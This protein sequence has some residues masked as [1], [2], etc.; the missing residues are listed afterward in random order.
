MYKKNDITSIFV[1]F[2]RLNYT[3]A[4]EA[5]AAQCGRYLPEVP[6]VAAQLINHYIVFA[7]IHLIYYQS[8]LILYHINVQI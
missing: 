4:A 1:G 2:T 7:I 3:V 8:Y 6:A 5:T